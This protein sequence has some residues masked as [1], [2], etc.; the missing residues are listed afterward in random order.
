MI[1]NCIY[2]NNNLFNLEPLDNVE[3]VAQF[4][5]RRPNINEDTTITVFKGTIEEGMIT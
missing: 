1:D 5:C 2:I 3:E 4:S